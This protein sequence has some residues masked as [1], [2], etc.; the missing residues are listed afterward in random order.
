MGNMR[1]ISID[2]CR[3]VSGGSVNETI[4]VTGAKV[5]RDD[6]GYSSWDYGSGSYGSYGGF[7][8]YTSYGG[9]G[10]GGTVHQITDEDS[11]G[12]GIPNWEDDP[13]IVDGDRSLP[14]GFVE[15][16]GGYYMYHLASDGTRG[17]LE[18]TPWYA[19]QV[20]EIY[21]SHQQAIDQ[22]S[23][24]YDYTSAGI[25]LLGYPAGAVAGQIMGYIAKATGANSPPQHCPIP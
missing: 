5:L 13:I 2:E 3:K 8:G 11:D 9:S 4:I 24:L 18:F 25:G 7:G 22:T 1:E 19:Q 12:D 23:S 20:C 15:V 6:G 16:A 14:A 17:P 21:D 10:G